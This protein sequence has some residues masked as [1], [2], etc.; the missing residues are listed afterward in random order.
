MICSDRSFA[1]S[2]AAS[3]RS[4]R[5][6]FVISA[7]AAPVHAFVS[8]ESPCQ[9]GVTELVASIRQFHTIT[10]SGDMTVRGS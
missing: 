2:M 8:G 1:S 6:Q 7:I 9:T 3:A 5:S 10:C 4:V